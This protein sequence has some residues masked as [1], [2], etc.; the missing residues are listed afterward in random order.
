MIQIEKWNKAKSDEE[1][2]MI[3]LDPKAVFT[4]AIENCKPLLT[5]QKVK[6]GGVLYMVSLTSETGTSESGTPHINVIS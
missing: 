6:R 1:R 3:E 5:T 2:E 4:K